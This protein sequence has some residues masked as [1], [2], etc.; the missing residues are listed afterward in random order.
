MAKKE[1]YRLEPLLRMKEREKRK[2]EMA[3]AKAIKALEEEKNKLISLEDFKKEI[4]EKKRKTES[5]MRE[6][7]ISGKARIKESHFHLDFLTK[8]KSD[9]EK[10][11]QEISEQKE[12]I[13]VAEGKLK[14]ARRDYMDA[15][16]ELNVMEK[17]RELWGKKQAHILSALE[18]KQMNELGNVVHQINRM[19]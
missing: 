9:I 19:R 5:S 16:S 18:N 7:V 14:R 6:R 4:I 12:S 8:L 10:T 3:L 15:A 1:K 11:D 2:M 17:H 13:G